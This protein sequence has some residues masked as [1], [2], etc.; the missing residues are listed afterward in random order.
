MHQV[1]LSSTTGTYQRVLT[2]WDVTNAL[3]KWGQ[4]ARGR[5]NTDVG[6]ATYLAVDWG[7]GINKDQGQDYGNEG[8]NAGK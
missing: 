5:E 2:T 4:S 6:H 1:F 3:R 8:G 7:H